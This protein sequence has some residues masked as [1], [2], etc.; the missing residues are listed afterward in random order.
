MESDPG[1]RWLPRGGDSIPYTEAGQMRTGTEAVT[2][3]LAVGSA[4]RV[5]TG[6]RAV[7]VADSEGSESMAEPVGTE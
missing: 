5:Q 6:V 1:T 4:G 2:E 3:G 7:A